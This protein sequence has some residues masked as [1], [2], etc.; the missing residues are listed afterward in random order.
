MEEGRTE[1]AV[2]PCRRRKSEANQ[3]RRKASENRF[4]FLN[5][6]PKLRKKR[7]PVSFNKYNSLACGKQ[8]G[9]H[10]SPLY[11][12]AGTGLFSTGTEKEGKI[13][14]ESP[15][16]TPTVKFNQKTDRRDDNDTGLRSSGKT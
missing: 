6:F 1:G 8:T 5:R 15:R 9:S 16:R 3:K 12:R 11:A 13:P 10:F 7:E 14:S 2:E 4:P